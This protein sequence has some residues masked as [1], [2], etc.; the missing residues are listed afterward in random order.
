MDFLI[1]KKELN[2]VNEDLQKIYLSSRN[3]ISPLIRS[4][5][6]IKGKGIRAALVILSARAT[7][8][9]NYKVT[10]IASLV[11]IIHLASLL[12]D[13]VIDNAD[14]RRGVPC[15]NITW[16]N[17]ASI[18]VADYFI[19]KGISVLCKDE[20]LKCIKIISDAV[21]CM[22][23][24]QLKELLNQNNILDINTYKDIIKEKTA[25]L[26]SS[27]CQMGSL[28]AGAAENNVEAMRQ[29]G[30]N[31]GMAYQL[32]DD[33]LDFWGNPEVVG[34]SM[35]R[36]IM[37]KNYTPPLIYCFYRANKNEQKIL[38]RYKTNGKFDFKKNNSIMKIMNKYDAKKYVQNLAQDYAEKSVTFLDNVKNSPEKLF[39]K[40]LTLKIINRKR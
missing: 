5:L 36:D 37:Q 32:T 13:D 16:G 29:F 39:L 17:K 23:T 27:A 33:V 2:K 14:I 21:S 9:M 38:R 7:G 6:G 8:R 25:T 3:D 10:R 26:F 28:L 40:N 11:E 12:H 35:G 19:S 31:F 4:C 34:K 15:A 20:Y 18:V 1:V 30:L 22:S 24:G